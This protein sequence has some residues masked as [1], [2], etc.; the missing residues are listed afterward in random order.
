[1][2]NEIVTPLRLTSPLPS[3]SVS[4]LTFPAME[5]SKGHKVGREVD[6]IVGAKVVGLVVGLPVGVRVV[7]DLLSTKFR[8]FLLDPVLSTIM[9]VL[10]V[11]IPL[12][13][14]TSTKP[15][16]LL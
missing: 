9:A 2:Y 8:F 10:S 3:S 4:S 16:R 5:P 7:G 6:R 13:S 15:G 11:R 12:E 1:M 14:Q